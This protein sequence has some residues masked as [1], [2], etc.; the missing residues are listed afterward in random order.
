MEIESPGTSESNASIKQINTTKQIST[1]PQSIAYFYALISG[2]IIPVISNILVFILV[3][4]IA[5][6]FKWITTG[7]TL[8]LDTGYLL[9]LIGPML[10]WAVTI[11]YLFLLV[12]FAYIYLQRRFVANKIIILIILI[13]SSAISFFFWQNTN[14]F[15]GVLNRLNPTYNQNSGTSESKMAE[16]EA[17]EIAKANNSCT[18]A[19]TVSDKGSYN[20]NSETWWVDISQTSKPLCSPA[21]VVNAETKEVEINWRCTGAIPSERDYVPGEIILKFTDTANE[22]IVRKIIENWGLKWKEGSPRFSAE[23]ATYI[24]NGGTVLVEVGKEEAW[25]NTLKK[26]SLVTSATRNGIVYPH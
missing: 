25:I 4:C 19:G 3:V 13:I 21:C 11:I 18:S 17:L 5:Y 12:M 2:F 15:E 14:P 20:E 6:L 22:E 16:S 7:I 26:E 8:E 9:I 1:K 23:G 24:N 10:I